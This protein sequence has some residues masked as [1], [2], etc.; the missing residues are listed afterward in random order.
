MRQPGTSRTGVCE[1]GGAQ[2]MSDGGQARHQGTDGGGMQ[3]KIRHHSG[4]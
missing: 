1:S 3:G 4:G 2:E